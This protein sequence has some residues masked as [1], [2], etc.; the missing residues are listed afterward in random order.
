MVSYQGLNGILSVVCVVCVS[1]ADGLGDLD[2]FVLVSMRHR[3]STLLHLVL[4]FVMC[5]C[6]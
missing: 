4:I 2:V 1:V 6:V 5:M 3:L